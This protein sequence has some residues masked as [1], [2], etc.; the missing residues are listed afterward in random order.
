MRRRVIADPATATEGELWTREV[1]AELRAAG[2]RPRAWSAFVAR[3][4]A[5]ARSARS[6]RPRAHR[7]TR[8]LAALGLAAWL[9][10]ALLGRVWL[11]LAGAAWWTL[12]AGMVDVH[13]GMLEDGAG[14][15]SERLG[16]A[17]LLTLSRT[18]LVP[19][20]PVLPPA[21]LV[22]G[23][24]LTGALD[25]LDGALARAFRRETRLGAWLDGGVDGFVL[26]AAAIGAGLDGRLPWW[27]V[28]LV[29]VRHGAQWAIV[30]FAWLTVA[31]TPDRRPRV[32]GKVPGAVLFAGL[33]LAC[34]RVPGAAPLVA[35]GALGGLATLGLT[36]ARARRLQL[37]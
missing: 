25:V 28:A 4:F 36:V 30:G 14:R 10:V 5:R 12:V 20:F 31:V 15:P 26:S 22:G 29:A 11:A 24:L 33:V 27:A 32:S 35:A 37:T 2:Y 19:A 7:E 1:V 34:L 8:A 16:V 21:A 18:A 17:N 3:S 6:S 13:L 23:L 9:G